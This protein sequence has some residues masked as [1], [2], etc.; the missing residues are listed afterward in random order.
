[1]GLL[2]SAA[3][4]WFWQERLRPVEVAV[5]VDEPVVNGAVIAPMAPR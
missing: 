5:G 2:L 1:M 4:L 3:L